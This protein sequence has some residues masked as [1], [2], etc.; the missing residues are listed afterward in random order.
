MKSSDDKTSKNPTDKLNSDFDFGGSMAELEQI[1][2]YLESSQ[3]N[4]DEA[5]KKYERGVQI[6]KDL[7]IYLKTA[8]NRV[9]TLKQSFDQD[10]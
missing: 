5:M 6:A 7:K 10:S 2:Q 9:Q 8:E 3:V 4:L 1:A